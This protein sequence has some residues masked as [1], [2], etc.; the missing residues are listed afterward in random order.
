AYI[1]DN[2][3][4]GVWGNGVVDVTVRDTVSARNLSGAAFFGGARAVLRDSMFGSNQVYGVYV[5]AAPTATPTAVR[6]DGIEVSNNASTGVAIVG[7]ASSF[8]TM[9]TTLPTAM[10]NAGNGVYAA[11]VAG[12]V[13][14]T[15]IDS[16]VSNHNTPGLPAIAAGGSAK[17]V[18]SRSV[19]VDNASVGFYQF[20]SGLFESLGDNTVRNNN[21]GGVQTAGTI[22]TVGGI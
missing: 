20:S 5:G 2:G 18:V 21:G 4:D 1:S 15:V 10:G 6:V 17:I 11:G 8:G 12:P 14:A 22:T 19:V 16:T 7:A 3:H 13:D 9:T